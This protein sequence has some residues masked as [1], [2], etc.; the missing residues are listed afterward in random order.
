MES[1]RDQTLEK[2]TLERDPH[3]LKDLALM[4]AM[5]KKYSR[6]CVQNTDRTRWQYEAN[7]ESDFDRDNWTNSFA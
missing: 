7:R 6:R 5:S 1:G 2:G 3:S 4:F